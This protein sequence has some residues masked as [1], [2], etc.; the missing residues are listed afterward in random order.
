[1]SAIRLP[2]KLMDVT[3]SMSKKEALGFPYLPKQSSV[4]VPDGR[5]ADHDVPNE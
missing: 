4:L 5:L 3:S 2:N 1:M